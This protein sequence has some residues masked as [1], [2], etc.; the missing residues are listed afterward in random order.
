MKTIFLLLILF[1]G[2]GLFASRFDGWA[3]L[4]LSV[5]VVGVVLYISLR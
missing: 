2:I 1:L 5:V 4:A 3:R